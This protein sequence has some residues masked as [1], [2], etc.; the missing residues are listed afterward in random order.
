[1][2]NLYDRPVSTMY[3]MLK[4]IEQ[5]KRPDINVCSVSASKG[6]VDYTHRGLEKS[7]TFTINYVECI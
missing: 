2:S 1:M 7:I 6:F 4:V 5:F 3:D